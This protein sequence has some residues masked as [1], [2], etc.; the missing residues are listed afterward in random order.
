VQNVFTLRLSVL[1]KLHFSPLF[2]RAV[3]LGLEMDIV[4]FFYITSF[5]ICTSGLLIILFSMSDQKDS[6]RLALCKRQVYFVV[7]R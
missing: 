5:C 2:G 6:C 7:N 3:L 4:V 1:D